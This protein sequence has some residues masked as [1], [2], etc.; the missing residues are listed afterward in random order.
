ME[1]KKVLGIVAGVLVLGGVLALLQDDDTEDRAADGKP[2]HS[3]GAPPAKTG[4]EP[5]ADPQ[6]ASG[7]PSPNPA[8]TADLL[9]RLGAIHPAT[10]AKE[11]KAVT[12][13]RN[14]CSDARWTEGD[15]AAV[16]A[17]AAD[18]FSGGDVPTLT[19]DQGAR[20]VKAVR[21]TFCP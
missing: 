21:E 2:K 10:V 19:P 7:V 16:N 14:V 20:I 17:R 12:R 15:D 4:G 18:R 8:Q 6:A 11:E 9:R 3:S 13:A 5:T 1:R